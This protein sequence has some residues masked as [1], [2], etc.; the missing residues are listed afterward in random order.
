MRDRLGREIS[1]L[2]LSVTD[3]CNLR[4]RYCIPEQ[5]NSWLPRDKILSYEQFARLAGLLAKLGINKIRLTGG[6][7]LVRRDLDRLVE[8][9]RK[10]TGIREIALT[11]NGVLLAEQLPGLV[12]AGL[13]AVNVSLDTLDRNQYA[14]IT[15]RDSLPQALNGLRAAL[16]TP[17]LTVKVNCVPIVKNDEQLV[18]I[19]SLAR[20]KNLAVRFIELMPLGAG[21][22]HPPRTER[23]V[24]EKLENA[25]GPA[26]P[27]EN[28]GNAGPA[29]YVTFAG[30]KGKVG[31]I[32]SLTAPFCGECSR[33]RLTAAGFLKTCLQY[34]TGTDLKPL[35]DA[36]A[37]DAEILETIKKAIWEKPRSHHFGGPL[38]EGD[39]RR[40]MNEIGG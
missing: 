39:E 18:P 38:T 17:G 15:R 34:E 19:A 7:P 12:K 35:L 31:F 9:L 40:A 11:T 6:E 20:D 25:F 26:R 30:F 24:L 4:C 1:Y 14:E 21:A 2:R 3:R 5:G 10:T 22:S 28:D 37:P 27:A 8:M 33:I 13:N 32:S 16:E 29:R 36:D 23:R